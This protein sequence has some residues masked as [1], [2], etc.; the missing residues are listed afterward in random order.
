MT[1][2]DALKL[3]ATAACVSV[4]GCSNKQMA[5]LFGPSKGAYLSVDSN[6]CT[7][8]RKCIAV[9]NADAITIVSN[10]AV[11]DPTKC[12]QCWKCVDACPYDAIY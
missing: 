12:I 2:L 3:M 9:C 11:V 7:G 5:Q 10:K 8:C 6:A 4:I 1:R